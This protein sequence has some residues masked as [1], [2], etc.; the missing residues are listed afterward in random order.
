MHGHQRNCKAGNPVKPGHSLVDHEADQALVRD[1]V[2][3]AT[4]LR[5]AAVSANERLD[6][7]LC[8]DTDASDTLYEPPKNAMPPLGVGRSLRSQRCAATGATTIQ[9]NHGQA[10]KLGPRPQVGAAGMSG[11]QLVRLLLG[12]FESHLAPVLAKRARPHNQPEPTI[13]NHDAPV[14]K[15]KS[16]T[17]QD[18]LKIAQRT[19][20][21]MVEDLDERGCLDSSLGE[22]VSHAWTHWDATKE[23]TAISAACI[24]HWSKIDKKGCGHK[25]HVASVAEELLSFAFGLA[26][27]M[28]APESHRRC[29]QRTMAEAR[30]CKLSFGRAANAAMSEKTPSRIPAGVALQGHIDP[31]GVICTPV[32][33]AAPR[34]R[35][36]AAGGSV[37]TWEQVTTVARYA[38]DRGLRL[39]DAWSQKPDRSS[40]IDCAIVILEFS[41]PP[42]RPGCYRT[43]RYGRWP[44][45][46]AKEYAE[47]AEEKRS[48]LMWSRD[49]GCYY[50]EFLKNKNVGPDG[51][52]C[53]DPRITPFIQRYCKAMKLELED[54][55][56][57]VGT[58]EEAKDVRQVA[59]WSKRAR[60]AF[61]RVAG[62][63]NRE[64]EDCKQP[65]QLPGQHKLRNLFTTWYYTAS[66]AST[67]ATAQQSV[68]MSMT[69]TVRELNRSYRVETQAEKKFYAEFVHSLST[70]EPHHNFFFVVPWWVD[71]EKDSVTLKKA[72][73]RVVRAAASVRPGKSAATLARQWLVN[74]YKPVKV[75]SGGGNKIEGY[76]RSANISKLPESLLTQSLRVEMLWDPEHLMWV[77]QVGGAV[78]QDAA[79]E[80]AMKVAFPL[81]KGGEP[82]E[83]RDNWSE[84][85][86]IAQEAGR[87]AGIGQLTG[88]DI[89]Y[90]KTK[91]ALAR[92]VAIDHASREPIVK[93]MQLKR[94]PHRTGV[95]SRGI[96]H[97]VLHGNCETLTVRRSDVHFPV[98]AR[99]DLTLDAKVNY[100]QYNSA[101]EGS[102]EL[103]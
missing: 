62:H 11:P 69:T 56:F 51:E 47:S 7:H 91:R 14:T 41:G 97:Y 43:L 12:E 100:L 60:D 85:L 16:S 92:V 45:R 76:K 101:E 40:L 21:L 23:I 3:R 70:H 18:W 27:K 32:G 5:L 46:K 59:T 102:S 88:G 54:A 77:T 67:D 89:V 25:H 19:V 72:L 24:M 33:C 1:A 71:L 29:I 50:L 99:T 75:D 8:D 36:K 22:N 28:N 44:E 93:L 64:C 49:Q 81:R 57:P 68:A 65:V 35:S 95:Q 84:A 80:T 78:G 90:V 39:L 20:H 37:A 38:L 94:S 82:S 15:T 55:F 96:S 30:K 52:N 2:P 103:D 79:L 63:C 34:T 61:D 10:Q 13:S 4:L 98:D 42:K 26:V 86:E 73:G 9:N 66:G 53:I 74:L 83:H 31:E 6:T 48:W 58:Y 17:L 87:Q